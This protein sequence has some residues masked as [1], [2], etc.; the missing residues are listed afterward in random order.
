MMKREMIIG[1]TQ[2]VFDMFHIGH[3]NLLRRAK[4]Q[5]DYLIVGVNS[6]QLVELYK[7]KVPVVHESER[8]E[9]IKAIRYVDEVFLAETLDKVTILKQHH[10]DVCFIG[11][12]WKGHPRWIKTE[13][14]L[15]EEGG[16]K[17]I[18]LDYTYRISS[19][20][21]RNNVDDRVKD[22]NE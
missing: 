11:S 8:I 7:K 19:T 17:V 5:C 18:Y 14:E 15:A 2:G 13:Q 21:L 3:L 6:D 4:E 16:V 12:D 10:Y 1:Y 9:I 22:R 20:K